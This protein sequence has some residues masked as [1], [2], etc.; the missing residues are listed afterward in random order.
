M[1]CFVLIMLFAFSSV[2]AQGISGKGRVWD[3]AFASENPVF[4]IRGCRFNFPMLLQYQGVLVSGDSSE[5]VND[6]VDMVFRLFRLPSGGKPVWEEGWNSPSHGVVVQNGLFSVTLGTLEPLS[7]ELFKEAL[8]LEIEVNGEVLQPRQKIVASAYSFRSLLSDTADFA[9]RADS[10]KVSVYADTAFYVI[11]S[12][13]SADFADSADHLVPPDTI[14]ANNS[15][16]AITIVNRNT[17]GCGL[18]VTIPYESDNNTGISVS[19]QMRYGVSVRSG[20]CGMRVQAEECGVT[21]KRARKGLKIGK[22]TETAVLVDSTPLGLRITGVDTGIDVRT[23]GLAAYLK[24]EVQIEGNINERGCL[25]ISNESDTGAAVQVNSAGCGVVIDS[26]GSAAILV[27]KTEADGIV[28]DSSSDRGI[29]IG[30]SGGRG[31]EIQSASDEG[32]YIANG[33]NKGIYIGYASENGIHIYQTGNVGVLIDDAENLGVL[34]M[35]GLWGAKFMNNGSG[36]TYATLVLQN[37][38]SNS[39]YDYIARFWS[40]DSLRFYFLTDGNA[41]A[42]HGWNVVSTT[43]EGKV[44]VMRSVVAPR[45]EMFEHGRAKLVDGKSYVEFSPEFAGKIRKGMDVDVIVTPLGG[46]ALYVEKITEKGFVVRCW[47][48][49]RNVEFAW[50]AIAAGEKAKLPEGLERIKKGW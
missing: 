35:G 45:E 4:S 5:P 21:I 25:N 49:D 47:N 27:R 12:P 2:K 39:S 29:V 33:G 48:G 15:G 9:Y 50:M 23:E 19:G 38:V 20:H 7:P 3:K 14:I 13:A 41:Y 42:A 43:K 8:W 34:S 44:A 31:V 10:V 22:C 36:S 6:T 18:N 26:V 17:E 46:A 28:I 11:N 16:S 1:K 40:R 32:I 30:H 37:I 24:G